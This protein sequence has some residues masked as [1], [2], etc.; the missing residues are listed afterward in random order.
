[1]GSFVKVEKPASPKGSFVAVTDAGKKYASAPVVNT[2]PAEQIKQEKAQEV[3]TNTKNRLEEQRRQAQVDMDVDTINSIDARLK[4]LRADAGLQTKAD[5]RGDVTGAVASNMVGATANA[6]GTVVN[7]FQD[8]ERNRREIANM[9]K[10]LDTGFN[11][12]GE[13][14]TKSQRQIYEARIAE[15]QEQI[16]AWEK[17]DTTANKLYEFADLASKETEQFTANAKEGLGDVGQFMVDV[18]IGAGQL[19]T[20]IA[21]NAILPGLGTAMMATRG[22]GGAAQEA[23]QSGATLGQQAAYGATSAATS[24]LTEKLFNVAAPFVKA[25]GGG[26]AGKVLN[27]AFGNTN[28]I[29]SAI[30][31]VAKN[32]AGKLFLSALSEGGEEALES[33]I[34]PVLK[35]LTYTDGEKV[36][37]GDV[38]YDALIGAALGFAGEAPS[39]INSALSRNSAKGSSATQINASEGNNAPK[40]NVAQNASK[41]DSKA[42]AERINN[43]AD[44]LYNSLTDLKRGHRKN[45]NGYSVGMYTRNGSDS[46]TI[47]IK[48]PNGEIVKYFIENGK[49]STNEQLRYEIAHKVAEIEAETANDG[50]GA[51]NLGF[52]PYSNLQNQTDKFHPEGPNAARPTDVPMENADGRNIPKSASTIYGAQGTTESGVQLLER[53]IA[54]GKIAFDTITDADSVATAQRTIADKSFEGALEQ[55]RQAVNSGVASKDNTTLGQQLLLQAMRDG[56]ETTTAELLSL[57]TRNSTTVAQALQAQ[58]IFRKLSP[59]GQL[60]AVQKAID[61]MNQKYGVEH[62]IDPADVKAFLEAKDES[63]RKEAE[64]TIVQKAAKSVPGTFKAKFDTIRYLAMLGNARTHIRN[65]LGN[66]LFQ[67]PVAVKNRVGAA[68]EIANN[69]FSKNKVERTKSLLGANPFGALAKDA[70]ADWANVKDFLSQNSKY[71]E[72]RSTLKDIENAAHSFSDDT[73]IGKTINTL[74][75]KNSDLLAA[76]DT[77][78]KRMIYTQSLAGYLKANG[79]KSIADASPDLLNR[80]RTYAANEALKNTFNDQNA[81]SD[82]VAKLGRLTSSSN[83]VVRGAGY[84]VEGVVPFKRTPANILVRAEEY[85]P[86]GAGVGIINT[87]RGAKK[88]DTAAISKGLDQLASGLTGVALMKLGAMAVANGW[89]TGGQSDDEKQEGFDELTGHQNYALELKDGTSVTL[90]WLAPEAIPFFVGVELYNAG[91][92]GETTV[93]EFFDAMGNATA[94]MLEMSMLQSLNDTVNNASYAAFNGGS[95]LKSLVASALTNYLTQAVPTLGGQIERSSEE[96]RM[97]TYTDKTSDLSTDMQYAIGKVSQKI[98][99]WDY[100]QIP[101]ID[102]WGRTESNGDPLERAAN[103]LFNPAYM[104][105][106][107]VDKVE[108]ELQR[109]YDADKGENGNVFPERADKS[110]TVNKATKNLTADE[111]V[112]YAKAKG[113][114]SYKLA[115]EA[116]NSVAY[117]RMSDAGKAAFIAQM[118]DYADYKAKKSVEP[119]HANDR[120]AK[121]EAAEKSGMSP[122]AY[123]V[124]TQT[125]DYDHSSSAG[126]PTQEEAQRYLD[127]ETNL[128]TKQKAD[129]WTIINKSWKNNP[130]Q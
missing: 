46:I 53:D 130:Y 69:V 126:Q 62:T 108:Q 23:R 87:I 4:Q 98:P 127:T 42:I 68:A 21:A 64:K 80:A 27:K 74:A 2:K 110:F 77:M 17:P 8:P 86:I 37:W 35:N 106:V 19:A 84:V 124:M 48:K 50:L 20:D 76:E 14:L 113:Q 79:C 1:M 33:L 117:Q 36:D 93:P 13:P 125:Y 128:S 6:A 112:K 39:T 107:E 58:S 16:K 116:I 115:Q 89:V 100:Q 105:Q 91:L 78:A 104:S 81:L 28:A 123:Y 44:E 71:S 30:A 34:Q 56:N 18:G 60:V 12:T 40:T 9:Q 97:T 3:Y 101:Y 82:A 121:Y 120:Y 85:S 65:I 83:P 103:N 96:Q 109:V 22:F 25:Y 122:S 5:R 92:N 129:M 67:V 55:Y 102:A 29:S 73:L 90:D 75:D 47:S 41:S 95:V 10:A 24:L 52:D 99:G 51:A 26:V 59:E 72:N 45:V 32:P 111:Y 7:L 11:V 94:P 88:G 114:N 54:N 57:Y 70:K 38:W 66:T 15:M 118:Y 63:T 49:Y 31:R 119:K 43:R 61:A